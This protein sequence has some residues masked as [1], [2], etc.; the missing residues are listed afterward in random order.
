MGSKR[1]ARLAVP[2]VPGPRSGWRCA[3][4]V[5]RACAAGA[6]LA[7][8]AVTVASAAERLRPPSAAQPELD[9]VGRAIARERCRPAQ[10][11]KR[12]RVPS[13][14]NPHRLDAVH[15]TTCAGF[16][17][18]LFQPGAGTRATA[19]LPMSV[20]LGA[21]HPRM[22]A[23]LAVGV[24]IAQVRERLGSPYETQGATLVYSLSAERPDDDLVSFQVDG[25]RV[26]SIVWSWNT[27]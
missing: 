15:T 20:T 27:D 22:P 24:P 23:E 26:S 14:A 1:W 16:E 3:R 2:G 9:R 7:A 12:E 11:V 4:Q 21:A 13:A 6:V 18:V 5:A 25:G 19:A 10:A 8:A 17:V